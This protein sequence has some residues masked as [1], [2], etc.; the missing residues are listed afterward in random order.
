VSKDT[1]NFK[2]DTRLASILGESYRSSEI[3]IKELVDN[4]W[5]AENVE[6]I[7]P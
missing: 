6:I 7:F 2:V 1:A 3:A 5:D 4:S